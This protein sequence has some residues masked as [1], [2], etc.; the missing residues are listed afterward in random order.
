[1]DKPL[2]NE[3]ASGYQKHIDLVE[4]GDFIELLDQN[5]DATIS[6]FK[7]IDGKCEN[8]R[9]EKDKWSIK[10]VL[11]HII[12][13]E[14]G[15]SYRAIVCVRNDDK[16]PLY[17]MDEKLYAKNVDVTN[18]SLNSLIE[19][20]IA[21]RK[22]FKFI[23]TNNPKEKFNFLANG[24]GHKISARAIGYIAIGHV[25]HHCS[26]IKTKYLV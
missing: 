8:F 24:I 10:E 7:S 18:S 14:R 1:M 2:E 3:Y 21:V 19:E 11:M 5:T 20:F 15:F 4:T 13:T 25:V 23:Y 16:T 9:Y 22:A 26:V 12:D 6:F 17:G